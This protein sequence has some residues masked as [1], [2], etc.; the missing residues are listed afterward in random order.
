MAFTNEDIDKLLMDDDEIEEK[1]EKVKLNS[2]LES[3]K[4][5]L[6]EKIQLAQEKLALN[7][8]DLEELKHMTLTPQQQK[9]QEKRLDNLLFL[10]DYGRAK[11]MGRENAGEI[12]TDEKRNLEVMKEALDYRAGKLQEHMWEDNQYITDSYMNAQKEM[13]NAQ[14]DSENISSHLKR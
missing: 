3:K 11:V 5:S 6:L 13:S 4:N 12:I 1:N 2:E 9:E 10:F 14:Q 7:D 8:R